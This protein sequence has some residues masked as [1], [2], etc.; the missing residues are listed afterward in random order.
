VKKDAGVEQHGRRTPSP[1]EHGFRQEDVIAGVLKKLR[2]LP[3]RD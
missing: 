2:Q 3:G 1:R